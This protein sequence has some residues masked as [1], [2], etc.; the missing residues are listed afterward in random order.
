MKPSEGLPCAQAE[1][2]VPLSQS[3]Q[4]DM[5]CES[6]YVFKHVRREQIAESEPAARGTEIHRIPATYIDHLVRVGRALD[7]EVFD[8]L[9]KTASGEAREV[10]ERFRDNHAFDPHKFLATELYIGCAAAI[11]PIHVSATD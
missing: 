3:R 11:V 10:L 6:L 1:T 4:C 5:A 7:L 2:L 9:M 8:Q